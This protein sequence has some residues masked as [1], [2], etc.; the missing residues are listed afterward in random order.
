MAMHPVVLWAAGGKVK[1]ILFA[2]R[3][4]AFSVEPVTDQVDQLA[5]VVTETEQF[6]PATDYLV[7]E[8]SKG[9]RVETE[10]VAG[11]LPKWAGGSVEGGRVILADSSKADVID[12]VRPVTPGDIVE[13]LDRGLPMDGVC[14]E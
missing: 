13:W 4:S 2:S 8:V 14:I 12:R 5:V 1:A 3:R 11:T 6:D 9:N 10:L 7:R